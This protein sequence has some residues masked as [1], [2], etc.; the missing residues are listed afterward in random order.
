MDCLPVD[1]YNQLFPQLSH[2]DVT[3]IACFN[4]CRMQKCAKRYSTQ[5]ERHS[6]EI[7][8]PGLIEGERAVWVRRSK[9]KLTG[10]PPTHEWITNDDDAKRA[11]RFLY[12]TLTIDFTGGEEPPP[13]PSGLE[14]DTIKHLIRSCL[15]GNVRLVF[16]SVSLC[17]RTLSIL[18]LI[19]GRRITFVADQLFNDSETSFDGV[20]LNFASRNIISRARL[21]VVSL[22]SDDVWDFLFNKVHKVE[23]TNCNLPTGADPLLF[24]RARLVALVA[25]AEHMRPGSQ[26]DYSPTIPGVKTYDM[27]KLLVELKFGRVKNSADDAIWCRLLGRNTVTVT[28]SVNREYVEDR[29]CIVVACNMTQ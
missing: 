7:R 4:C 26:I 28:Y 19:E 16:S 15:M 23:I 8:Y 24:F 18:N 20:F 12:S 5:Y 11:M 10:S 3:K 2:D 17:P 27:V 14:D 22:E 25:V 6:L 1:F 9:Y 29:F 13:F 21:N